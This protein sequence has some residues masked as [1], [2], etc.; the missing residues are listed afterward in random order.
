MAIETINPNTN[1]LV[2]TFEKMENERVNEIIFESEKAF[3]KW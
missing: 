2:K 1:K 3:Q